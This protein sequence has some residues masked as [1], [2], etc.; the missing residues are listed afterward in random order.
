MAVLSDPDR[1]TVAAEGM[2]DKRLGPLVGLLKA[3]WRAAVDAA[4]TWANSNAAS[5][6][7]ALPVAARNN[8]TAG[9]KALLL[10]FVVSKRFLAGS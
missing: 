3:D 6:N 2:R 1:A 5:F 10:M 9:Q 8:L 7:T 4:D